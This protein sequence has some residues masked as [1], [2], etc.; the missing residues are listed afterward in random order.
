MG[1]DTDP[2]VGWRGQLQVVSRHRVWVWLPPMSLGPL[3]LCCDLCG[4]GFEGPAGSRA[5]SL[6]PHWRQMDPRRERPI[7]WSLVL[8]APLSPPLSFGLVL[9]PGIAVDL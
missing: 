3:L 1:P 6:L 7:S 5:A 2:L 9:V 4:P 8:M